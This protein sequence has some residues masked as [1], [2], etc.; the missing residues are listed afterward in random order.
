MAT[1]TNKPDENQTVGGQPP[2]PVSGGGPAYVGMGT[3]GAAQ[4]QQTAQGAPKF[5]G[6]SQFLNA[7][8]GAAKGLG[9]AINTGVT[10]QVNQGYGTAQQQVGDVSNVA[11]QAQGNLAAAQGFQSK[12]GDIT[13]AS[14]L[15][16][17]V[18]KLGQFAGLKTGQIQQKTKEQLAK[19]SGEATQAVGGLKN[20]TTG[21]LQNLGSEAGR[22]QL[23]NQYV[24]QGHRGYGGMAGKL[25]QALLQRDTTGQLGNARA[26]IQD[27]QTNKIGGLE[28]TFNK[29][30][31]D[32]TAAQKAAEAFGGE[33]GSLNTAATGLENQYKTALNDPAAIAAA[34]A[35]RAA[36]QTEMQDAIDV[37]AGRKEN[38]NNIDLGKYM[39]QFGLKA[40][41]QTF[42]FFNNPDFKAENYINKGQM[43]QSGADLISDP[44]VAKYKALANL[45]FTGYDANKNAAVGPRDD[46][47]AFTKAGSLDPAVQAA[48][49]AS[50]KTKLASG[51]G[52][53][54]QDFL[55]KAIGTN[56]VGTGSDT[57]NDGLFGGSGTRTAQATTNLGQ[58]LQQAGY[59]PSTYSQDK[60]PGVFGVG[61]SIAGAGAGLSGAMQNP[62]LAG[63]IA[64]FGADM[65]QILGKAADQITGT[66][67]GNDSQSGAQSAAQ[68]NAQADLRAKVMAQLKEMGYGNVLGTKG[69]INAFDQQMAATNADRALQEQVEA[70]KDPFQTQQQGLHINALGGQAAL[71]GFQDTAENRALFDQYQKSGLAGNVQYNDRDLLAAAGIKS[72]DAY[73][74]GDQGKDILGRPNQVLTPQA[75][76]T[77]DKMKQFQEYQNQ[78]TEK[79]KQLTASKAAAQKA[80][81]DLYNSGGIT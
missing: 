68:R 81:Q 29:A 27:V 54:A 37:L 60:A 31:A 48:M 21:A 24:G 25:D 38:T 19:E 62:M 39:N 34:N 16:G 66:I 75:K 18:S 4:Q 73:L 2:K 7:N 9:Q 14:G 42:G 45:A 52:S 40:G 23:L 46:Q 17:D 12:L 50:G 6:V 64:G 57:Y 32:A 8:K 72:D 41:T 1:V 70:S 28:T 55:T 69:Q 30:N 26:N 49:D 59:N 22:S 77:L 35:K 15:G 3:G 65:G 63:P 44:E 36:Q 56:V 53:A 10:G 20:I 61:D 67:G 76:Q 78:N 74:K 33:K 79:T 43:A 5:A 80:L 58:L 13:Q 11:G 51:L 71:G 47:Y